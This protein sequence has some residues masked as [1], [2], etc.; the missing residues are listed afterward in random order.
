MA[1]RVALPY[2]TRYRK[3]PVGL[4]SDIDERISEAEIETELGDLSEDNDFGI[5]TQED[6]DLVDSLLSTM[7]DTGSDFTLT[8][9]LLLLFLLFF[10]DLLCNYIKT[11]S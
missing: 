3:Y 11:P 10:I 4:S 9:R 7:A 6:K 5:I 1:R 2:I 8:F